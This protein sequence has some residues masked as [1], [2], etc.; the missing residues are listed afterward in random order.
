MK[1]VGAHISCSLH[2]RGWSQ[3]R[4]VEWLGGLLFSTKARGDEAWRCLSPDKWDGRLCD[5]KREVENR[6]LKSF[7]ANSVNWSN[8]WWRQG[9]F[10]CILIERHD[11]RAYG[12]HL[13]AVIADL[14]RIKK[15]GV[16]VEA[17][18]EIR[19]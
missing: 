17:E 16:G 18:A 10:L 6:I 7:Q 5:E 1:L 12:D 19:S 11:R 14:E 9:R 13:R 3:K 15:L 2:T 4:S 8:R